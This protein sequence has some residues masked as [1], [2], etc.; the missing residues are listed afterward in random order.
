MKSGQIATGNGIVD[1]PLIDSAPAT[2]TVYAFV[3]DDNS[4][5]SGVYQFAAN[6]A[7]GT[8][9]LEENMGASSGST[10]TT[11]Y[12]GAFDNLHYD[13]AGGTGGSL[14][15]CAGTASNPLVPAVVSNRHEFGFHWRR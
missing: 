4:A 8:K 13:I 5:R 1:A 11:V 15:V 2:P 12:D 7:S 9:G 10:S 6:F 14:Y 3:G